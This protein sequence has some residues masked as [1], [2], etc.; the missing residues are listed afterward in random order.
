ML[1]V[2][3]TGVAVTVKCREKSLRFMV[4]AGTLLQGQPT[5]LIIFNYPHLF[6]VLLLALFTPSLLFI[7]V[8]TAVKLET[9]KLP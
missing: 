6:N 1:I 8:H 5:Q 3:Y 2:I 7:L 9:K 4:R